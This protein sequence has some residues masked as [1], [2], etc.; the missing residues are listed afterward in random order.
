MK[1]PK[2]L[3]IAIVLIIPFF[4]YTPLSAGVHFEPNS[5]STTAQKSSA[6][7]QKKK[8]KIKRWFKSIKEKIKNTIEEGDNTLDFIKF[9]LAGG[10]G[11]NMIGSGIL[12]LSPVFAYNLFGITS[13]LWVVILLV[14]IVLLVLSSIIGNKLAKKLNE[15]GIKY[16]GLILFST[17]IV[18]TFF[19]AFIISA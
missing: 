4:N 5:T 12:A 17:L 7:P 14:G 19:M 11:M 9:Y 10:L 1:L 16:P 2:S 18:V 8:G 6:K 13:G 3:I 15:K